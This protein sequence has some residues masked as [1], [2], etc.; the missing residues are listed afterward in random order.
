MQ[1]DLRELFDL[2]LSLP[3]I[4]DLVIVFDGVD[5]CDDLNSELA[6]RL[7]KLARLSSVRMA[8]FSR[9]TVGSLIKDTPGLAQV[10]IANSNATDIRQYLHAELTALHSNRLLPRT[11]DLD[12]VAGK[13]TSRAD[14]MF[15]WARL[16]VSY[17]KC[18]ALTPSQRHDAIAEL[19]VPEGLEKMYERIIEQIAQAGKPVLEMAGKVIMWLL[20]SHRELTPAQLDDAVASRRGDLVYSDLE[21]VQ[22]FVDTVITV[23]GGFVEQEC[24]LAAGD[25]TL[26]PFRFI[27]ASVRDY[28]TDH[29]TRSRDRGRLFR[30]VV[31]LPPPCEAHAKLG[32][33]SMTYLLETL[34]HQ[35]LSSGQYSRDCAAGLG[36]RYPLLSY[37]ASYW[38]VHLAMT[39]TQITDSA[40][41]PSFRKEAGEL[42]SM[43][44][45]FLETPKAIMTWIEV[46]YLFRDE[47][48]ARHLVRLAS[49]MKDSATCFPGD[50]SVL[51]SLGSQ[52][53]ELGGYLENVNS[54]WGC[55]LRSTP[56][57]IWEEVGAFSPSRFVL[58]N[59]D[60]MVKRFVSAA[61][62][63]RDLSDKPINKIS[64]LNPDGKVDTVLSIYPTKYCRRT[65]NFEDTC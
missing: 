17:L 47:V 56:S 55:H 41:K 33:I 53:R 3:S 16:M 36:R 46:C 65:G 54:Q 9:P 44:T 42:V 32:S 58:K 14:G 28:F 51:S 23:C 18:V 10:A 15:L 59:S 26:A 52:L 20:H 50:A 38:A 6:G 4:R 8:L 2:C 63:N 30:K 29:E 31:F 60:M 25:S 19:D 49:Y 48:D 12:G 40:A 7:R 35:P 5:E 13:L 57:C 45:Q 39:M 43:L 21:D 1:G 61:P 27:H 37:A 62:S 64:R 24:D 34:P 22:D 11:T